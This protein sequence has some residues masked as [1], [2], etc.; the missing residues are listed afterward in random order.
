MLLVSLLLIVEMCPVFFEHPVKVPL[1]SVLV[2]HGYVQHV[3]SKWCGENCIFYHSY[4]ILEKN[5]SSS[6]ISFAY[7]SSTAL[8]VEKHWLSVEKSRDEQVGDSY[9]E[10]RMRQESSRSLESARSDLE[11]SV[12]MLEAGGIPEE[13]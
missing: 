8:R 10:P 13:E 7:G 9:D 2:G 6:A 12:F 3:G 4:L 11:L 1:R 5:D